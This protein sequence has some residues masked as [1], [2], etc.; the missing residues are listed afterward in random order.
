MKHFTVLIRLLRDRKNF[1]DE[2]SHDVKLESKILSLLVAS[3]LF[4]AVYGAIIGASSSWL[5]MLSSA[6]KLPALYLV[7]L[8]IC[9]PTLYFFDILFG[10]QLNFRQY[11]VMALTSVSTISVLLFSF[12]PIVLFFLISVQGYDFFLLLNVAVMAL[13][14]FVGVKLFYKGMRIIVGPDAIEQ[15]LRN[16]LLKGWV[17]LYGLVGSQLGWTLRPFFGAPNEPFQIFR[18]EIE[19][20]FYAQVFILIRSL[21]GL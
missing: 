11:T 1:L 16:R 21:F 4:F 13:T 17:V 3:S 14:G 15:Q 8:I 9:L 19:G 12:A 5:Q 7:T 10:S 20:N 6:I 2:I 18:P